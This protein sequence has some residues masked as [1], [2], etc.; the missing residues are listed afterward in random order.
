MQKAQPLC[1]WEG[2]LI[3][4]LHSNRSYWNVACVYFAAR[5]CLPSRCLEM[6]VCSD[7]TIPS[8]G[9]HVTL[10]TAYSSIYR[11]CILL[12]E[13]VPFLIIHRINCSYSSVQN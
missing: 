1:C 10:Y 8:F 12:T 5:E 9:L 7:F 3:A 11:G 13:Y 2:V 4:P 6:N